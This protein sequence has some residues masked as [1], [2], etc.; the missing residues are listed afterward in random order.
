MAM[1]AGL[2][3]INME[4]YSSSY[5]SIGNFELNLGSPRN[6]VQPAA[7]VT[8]ASGETIIPR[9]SFYD[10]TTLGKQKIDAVES[11][12][13]FVA[14]FRERPPFFQW[15]REGKGP[16]FL[17]LTGGT[18]EEI[19]YIEWS[20]GNEGKGSVFLDYL[21]KQENFDFRKDKL[22][23]LPN[24]REMAGT[25]ASGLMVDRNMET[26]VKNLFG[27]GDDVG[28]VP[29]MCSPGAFTMGWRAGAN[30]ASEALKQKTLPERNQEKLHQLSE[31]CSG[32]TDNSRGLHWREVEMAVQQIVDHY[33]GE[34]RS[35]GM[36]ARGTERLRV[37]RQAASFSAAN[38]HELMRCL[39][40][41]S[42]LDN[43]D[44]VFAAS[45]E[46]KESRKAPFGFF[47]ADFPEQD[48][49]EWLAFLQLRRD[50][51]SFKFSKIPITP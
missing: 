5:F 36:L 17:D 50:G 39:E 6:T 3:V 7:A 4:F 22:E 46:R 30:A 29:W 33:A 26:E 41:M 14:G 13:A 18:E 42:V 1:R 49:R 12:K 2:P 16:F 23:W 35:S 10:W 25:A 15:H 24:S 43:A 47:R 51:G 45:L 32:I 37:V 40:V 28:G 19:R 34:V 48:D 38:P 8:G 20:I 31:L 21:K 44:M 11:R 27:A 9:T